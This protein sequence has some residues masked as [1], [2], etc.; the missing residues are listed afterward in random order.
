MSATKLVRLPS[1]QRRSW[2]SS[3][4]GLNSCAHFIINACAASR[5]FPSIPMSYIRHKILLTLRP[6]NPT[7]LGEQGFAGHCGAGGD[8]GPKR[9]G[10]FFG[11]RTTRTMPR[12]TPRRLSPHAERLSIRP[13]LPV[14]CL[15]TSRAPSKTPPAR[16]DPA[17]P[18]V[19]TSRSEEK[20]LAWQPRRRASCRSNVR[21]RSRDKRDVIARRSSMI[22]ESTADMLHQR[23]A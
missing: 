4:P 9:F 19:H 12:G 23:F 18:S 13:P 11:R 10:R 7:L 20:F 16:R 14:P 22:P 5:H 8:V 3:S 6:A 15:A 2:G 1:H 17:A 21:W